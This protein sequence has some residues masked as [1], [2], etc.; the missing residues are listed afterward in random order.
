MD[1]DS[2]SGLKNPPPGESAMAST[3]G[4]T[5]LIAAI[6]RR[7]VSDVRKE[8]VYD[9]QQYV[10]TYARDA[11]DFLCD[12]TRVHF[13]AE[14]LGAEGDTIQQALLRNAGLER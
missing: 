1:L 10:D 7:A 8:S 12:S 6:L 9:H 2:D 4:Y 3:D 5:N 11:E 14:L 13:F